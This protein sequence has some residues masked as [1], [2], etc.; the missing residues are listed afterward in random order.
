MVI[1]SLYLRPFPF[2]FI[3]LPCDGLCAIYTTELLC[4]LF[5]TYLQYPRFLAVRTGLLDCLNDNAC[6]DKC[7]LARSMS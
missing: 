3:F 2:L 4:S 5:R 6:D 1:C 7:K